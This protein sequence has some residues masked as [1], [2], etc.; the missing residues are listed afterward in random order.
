MI[1]TV[2]TKFHE[3]LKGRFEIITSGHHD[4]RKMTV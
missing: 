1:S 4:C 2:H 3:D